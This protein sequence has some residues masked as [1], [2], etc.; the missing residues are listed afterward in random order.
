MFEEINNSRRRFFGAA[1]MTIA[2]AQLGDALKTLLV[3]NRIRRPHQLRHVTLSLH[4]PLSHHFTASTRK[5]ACAGQAASG[6]CRCCGRV[7]ARRKDAVIDFRLT[8][9]D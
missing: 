6:L 7:S 8:S 5:K 1:A 3:Q 9:A 4:Q 2:A